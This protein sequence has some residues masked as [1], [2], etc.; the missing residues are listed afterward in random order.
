RAHA[1][2]VVW[3]GRLC[4]A[5]CLR[6]RGE[7]AA[8]ARGF[9]QGRVGDSACARRESLAHLPSVADRELTAGADGKS[10]RIAARALGGARI[11]RA[12]SARIATA[13]GSRSRLSSGALR[14]RRV[15]PDEF[16]RRPRARV[17]RDAL[18]CE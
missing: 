7:S 9:T 2:A 8:G 12:R 6:E 5:D 18:E 16:A 4:A 15:T 10:A 13:R 17:A 14:L 1:L 11:A 3:R